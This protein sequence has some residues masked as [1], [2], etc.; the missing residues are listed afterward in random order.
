MKTSSTKQLQENNKT[1][2]HS[3]KRKWH[4]CG[5]LVPS[6]MRSE[7]EFSWSS[8][9]QHFPLHT[10][11]QLTRKKWQGVNSRNTHRKTKQHITQCLVT[12]KGVKTICWTESQRPS[13]ILQ[14]VKSKRLKGPDS[15][16][17]ESS[18]HR[19]ALG[20]RA[21]STSLPLKWDRCVSPGHAHYLKRELYTL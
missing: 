9:E 8:D 10:R 13:Q 17:T 19:P 18:C 5:K 15:S 21:L 1:T 20:N 11:P 14:S 12:S 6:S 2:A 3:R 4:G 16:G 7:M